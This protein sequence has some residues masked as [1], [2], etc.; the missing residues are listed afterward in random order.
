MSTPPPIP[1]GTTALLLN[2]MFNGNLRGS[3]QE[4]TRI[5]AESGLIENTARCVAACRAQGIQIVWICVERRPDRKDVFA[6]I[7]DV[8]LA[9]PDRAPH[10]VAHGTWEAENVDE[11]PI[12]P[13]DHVLFKPRINP[14]IATDLDL[15]LRS[16]GITT[17]MLGGYSTN[18]GVEAAVRTARDLNYNVVTLSDCC[19]NAKR[20]LHEFSLR[21][22]MPGFSRVMTGPEAITLLQ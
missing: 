3:N 11:L 22:I 21:E 13:E 6:N 4:T 20:E 9:N 14:F 16:R 8:S 19:F 17:V 12:Q 1:R 10:V 7:T 18:G 15:F 5:I 2:D